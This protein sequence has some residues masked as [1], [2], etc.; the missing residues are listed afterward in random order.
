MFWIVLGLVGVALLLLKLGALSVWVQL[1][2]FALLVAGSV[3]AV[4]A[5][6]YLLRRLVRRG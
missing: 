3:L 6:V 4:S 1:L 2:S 5:F